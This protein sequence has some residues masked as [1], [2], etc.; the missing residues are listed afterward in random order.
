[1]YCAYIQLYHYLSLEEKW[2]NLAVLHFSDGVCKVSFF[3]LPSTTPRLRMADNI[4][5]AV[6]EMRLCWACARKSQ[7]SIKDCILWCC[8]NNRIILVYNTTARNLKSIVIQYLNIFFKMAWLTIESIGGG[9]RIDMTIH[10]CHCHRFNVY[11]SA[12]IIYNISSNGISFSST[13]SI[14]FLSSSI[15]SNNFADRQFEAYSDHCPGV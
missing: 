3:T 2:L 11:W 8:T 15:I 9:W 13:F 14:I 5:I 4:Q 10:Y 12:F 6:P 7:L 1:M